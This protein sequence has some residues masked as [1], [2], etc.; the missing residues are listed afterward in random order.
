MSLTGYLK[1]KLN[2]KE[3]QQ[4]WVLRLN[5]QG[6]AE[7]KLAS[8]LNEVGLFSF[9]PSN[10][11]KLIN[12]SQVVYYLN[13][14]WK[15]LENGYTAGKQAEVEI[16]HLNGDVTDDAPRNLVALST[17]DHYYVSACQNGTFNLQD[18]FWQNHKA[19]DN[20]TPFNNQGRAIKNH[21]KFLQRIIAATIYNTQRW[22]EKAAIK[23]GAKIKQTVHWVMKKLGQ[24][25]EKGVQAIKAIAVNPQERSIGEPLLNSPK[26][27]YRQLRQVLTQPIKPIIQH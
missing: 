12:V 7:V 10:S 25:V 21:S 24:A 5:A 13:H 4:R 1:E 22:L 11:G 14:G 2:K 8:L 18:F 3:E 17:G 16:H 27:T 20:P 15:A 26:T 23:V 19:S 6:V 9:Y